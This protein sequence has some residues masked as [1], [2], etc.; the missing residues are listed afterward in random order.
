MAT[1]TTIPPQA[2]LAQPL[3]TFANLQQHLAS[4]PAVTPQLQHAALVQE[5]QNLI[6]LVNAKDAELQE[7][8]AQLRIAMFGTPEEVALLQAMLQST[9]NAGHP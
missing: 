2:N 1:F 4:P 7:V 3:P 5:V 8:K 6:N 9:R